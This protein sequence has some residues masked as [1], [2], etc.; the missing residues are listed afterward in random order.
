MAFQLKVNQQLIVDSTAY[1]VDEHPAAPGMP[2]GQEGRQATVYQLS[3]AKD[4]R[5]LKVFKPRYRIPALVMLADRLAS[6]SNLSGLQVCT[7]VVLNPRRHGELL[8]QCPDLTYAVLMPWMEGPTWMEMLLAKRDFPPDKSLFLA[9][10]LAEILAGMEERSVAHCDLSGPNVLLPALA[11]SPK[12]DSHSPIEL[13]DVEQLYG[14]GLERP[15]ALPGG[16]PSYAHRMAPEGLWGSKADRF[17]GAVLIAEMLGWCDERIRDAAWG[18][19]YFDPDEMQ[20]ET[21]RC[22]VLVTVLRDRWGDRVAGLFERAWHSETLADCAPFGEW[23]VTL[24][25]QVPVSLPGPLPVPG[26]DRGKGGTTDD[27]IRALMDLARQFEKAGNI[28]S[29]LTTYRQAQTQAAAG[30]GL[31]QELALIVKDLESRPQT[32]KAEERVETGAAVRATE[33]S[34]QEEGAGARPVKQ[35]VAQRRGWPTWAT[36][37]IIVVLLVGALIYGGLASQSQIAAQSQANAIA[38]AEAIAN[39]LATS[40]AQAEA[41]TTAIAQASATARAQVSATAQAQMDAT[42]TVQSEATKT[43]QAPGPTTTQA[44]PTATN[45]LRP[46]SAAATAV[47]ALPS[48]KVQLVIVNTSSAGV[49]VKLWGPSEQQIETGAGETK[50]QQIPAGNYGWNMFG[51]GCSFEQSDLWRFDGGTYRLDI[52]PGTGRCGWAIRWPR[53]IG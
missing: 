40:N 32:Q 30:S 39:A 24:P 3:A 20:Q 42:A 19:N 15:E 47:P 7:R 43:V 22:R 17:A 1:H 10:A 48:G 11:I 16:S 33:G 5:A 27:A 46:A 18:E 25:D 13:V 6:F 50:S 14:P 52:V 38:A 36:G 49:Q 29:A 12:L 51:N 9:R 44:R 21:D 8:R 37:L 45:T 28:A 53:R 41:T 23:L 4:C 26:P 2:Y 31:A 35:E 34:T